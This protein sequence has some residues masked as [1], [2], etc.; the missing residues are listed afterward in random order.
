[1]Q[2][3]LQRVDARGLEPECPQE[4]SLALGDGLLAEYVCVEQLWVLCRGDRAAGNR[5]R[6]KCG[7]GS[8]RLV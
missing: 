3:N 8:G 2:D 7:N 4:K 1:M 5:R 6:V